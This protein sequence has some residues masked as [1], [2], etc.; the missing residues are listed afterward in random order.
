MHIYISADIEGV[1]G[2]VS[3]SQTVQSGFEYQQARQWMTD[4]V[5]AACEGA[6]AGGATSVTVS[7]SH[8]NGQNLLLERF[9]VNV[10]I[11]RN[12]PRPLGMMQGV[13]QDTPAGV[14]LL[15]YHTGAHHAEGVLAHTISGRL[16]KSLRINDQPATE[17]QLSLYI[18]AHY[19]VPVIFA[20]GD[21]Q[22]IAY[23]KAALGDH[24][25]TVET[26]RAT[27]RYSA[28]TL[29][30]IASCAAIRSAAQA[31]VEGLP[32]QPAKPAVTP[33]KL[34]V[35]FQRH[36]PAE[37]LAFLPHFERAGST[38]IVSVADD[39]VAASALLQFISGV[40]FDEQLP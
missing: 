34:E 16:I 36:L 30:P 15:G 17:T 27:G 8:G 38:S 1:A 2:V 33:V 7:D 11:V 24:A 10:R 19:E 12:W 6:M 5:L 31:A 9:P 35:E 29:S 39:I 4:E 3:P 25:F 22:F 32:Q 21:N 13:E 28:N 20:S 40:T 14:F 37:L 18:A 26:K 23:A